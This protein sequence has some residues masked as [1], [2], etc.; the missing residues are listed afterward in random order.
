M[1]ALDRAVAAIYPRTKAELA[2]RLGVLPQ[3]ITNWY[4]RGIPAA[5]CIA[6]EEATDGAVTRYD[7]RPDVFGT[8]A[9][10][11]EAGKAVND[12]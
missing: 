8:P 5:R 11:S 4:S 2:R 1:S 10:D 7:L 3:H 6:I 12:S 9:N